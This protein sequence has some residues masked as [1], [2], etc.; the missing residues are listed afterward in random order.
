MTRERTGFLPLFKSAMFVCASD[1]VSRTRNLS[2][3][4]LLIS[5]VFRC[6]ASLSCQCVSLSRVA[7]KAIELTRTECVEGGGDTLV[8]TGA[9]CKAGIRDPFGVQ[10]RTNEEGG[11]RGASFHQS[12]RIGAKQND[13]TERK[14]VKKQ[15]KQR[16]RKVGGQHEERGVLLRANDERVA[17]VPARVACAAAA[18]T[19]RGRPDRRDCEGAPRDGP[20]AENAGAAAAETPD[21]KEGRDVRRVAL[22]AAVVLGCLLAVALALVLAPNRGGGGSGDDAV[23]VIDDAGNLRRVGSSPPSARPSQWPTAERPP[24]ATAPVN[25]ASGIPVCDDRSG[26]RVCPDG[27]TVFRD[28]SRDCDFFPCPPPPPTASPSAPT[29]A[30]TGPTASAP[31]PGL[32]P[33]TLP[34]TSR[35]TSRPATVLP[36]F[37]MTSQS[38]TVRLTAPSTPRQTTSRPSA[39]PPT[40]EAATD[41]PTVTPA[42]PSIR[43]TSRPSQSMPSTDSPSLLP[44]DAITLLCSPDLPPAA[45]CAFQLGGGTVAL[46]QKCSSSDSGPNDHFG[47][48]LAI[49]AHSHS[50]NKEGD[51]YAVVGAPHHA[52]SG[53]AYL[54]SYDLD[55]RRWE[56]V[57]KFVPGGASAN[58]SF[59]NSVRRS[60]DQFGSDVAVSEDWVAI[61]APFS[62][63]S[64]GHVELFRFDD[65]LRHGGQ[66]EP[67][68]TLVADDKSHLS[69]FGTAVALERNCLVVGAPND[70]ENAGSA[71]IFCFDGVAWRQVAKLAPDDASSDP[72]GNFGHSVAAVTDPDDGSLTVAVGAPFDGSNGRRR[73]GSVYVYS[74]PVT[75]SSLSFALV[76]KIVPLELLEGDQFGSSLAAVTTPPGPPSLAG[77]ARRTQLAIGARLRD[78][79]GIDSGAVYLYLHRKERGIFELEKK[80]APPS[81][82]LPGAEIGASVAADGR[83]VLAGA[84]G[85]DGTGGAYL[86]R[87]KDWGWADGELL[88]P[89]ADDNGEDFGSAVALASHVALVGA[90]LNGAVYSYPVCNNE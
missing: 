7:V 24:A 10:V 56:H 80:L 79:R 63:T 23:M 44:T 28:P 29:D 67:E 72:S 5:S 4:L 51:L 81:W 25:E 73:N 59:D 13:T 48:S 77:G 47:S 50:N 89:D 55:S 1:A 76:Q 82:W 20:D 41:S 37:V 27:A 6:L 54:L 65:I 30:A 40:F 90:P 16:P 74:L 3:W 87:H 84:R 62:V 18:E 21:A 38:P 45:P 14:V 68:A 8:S 60:E 66:S 58:G 46:L 70:R 71:Y 17:S 75:S 31:F 86:F 12:R 36:T 52:V 15:S 42:T 85:L 9:D 49:I 19:G 39:V 53:T 32:R 69:H 88:S 35:P 61:S 26:G 11:A 64:T 83:K 22:A 78:D 33:A 2:G 43:P 34:P 57:A